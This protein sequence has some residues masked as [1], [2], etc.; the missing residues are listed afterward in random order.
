[1]MIQKM[2]MMIAKLAFRNTLLRCQTRMSILLFKVLNPLQGE[3]RHQ[4]NRVKVPSLNKSKSNIQFTKIA[5]SSSKK[6]F[7]PHLIY[8]NNNYYNSKKKKRVSSRFLGKANQPE[9]L[10]TEI[11]GKISIEIRV[12]GI[13]GALVSSKSK[14]LL[15][16]LLGKEMS[17]SKDR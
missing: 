7:N 13:K 2:K 12:I 8:N 14:C 16:G 10:T 11:K 6:K 1:M 5:K 17:S 9:E 15:R 3:L 4:S